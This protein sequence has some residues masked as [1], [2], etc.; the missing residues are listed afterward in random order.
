MTEPT[1]DQNQSTDTRTVVE[2]W[3]AEQQ[4]WQK[5]ALAYMDS[6][7]G[8]EDFLVN[9]GNAMRGSLL[10]GKPYPSAPAPGDSEPQS[11]TDDRSDAILHALH[12]LQGDL[13]D[14]R[15]AVDG[16]NERLDSIA[17]QAGPQ[18]SH[19]PAT[20]DAPQT[21]VNPADSGGGD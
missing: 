12:R 8:N 16:L 21:P 10:A 6:M 19:A 9:L 14:L 18:V 11:A 7:V 4:E 1:R 5:T 2:R 3:I 20:P 15:A 13:N 17:E